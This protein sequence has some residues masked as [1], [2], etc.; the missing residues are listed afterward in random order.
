M[1]QHIV[2]A[3]SRTYR[4]HCPGQPSLGHVL[5]TNNA[6]P[7]P[8]RPLLPPPLLDR[9]EEALDTLSSFQRTYRDPLID[10]ASAT[11]LAFARTHLL[12]LLPASIRS[13]ERAN[14]PLFGD[15]RKQYMQLLFQTDVDDEPTDEEQALRRQLAV[16]L[17]TFGWTSIAAVVA[18]PLMLLSLP[19]LLYI[20]G[21]FFHESYRQ[22]VYERRFGVMSLASISIIGILQLGKLWA[23][24]FWSILF[25]PGN[26]LIARTRRTAKQQLVTLLGETPRFV[27][28]QHNDVDVRIPF[29]LLQVNDIIIVGAGETIPID[30]T[31]VSGTASI[32][33]HMLTGEAQ[34]AEKTKDERVYAATV[35][36]TGR[37]HILVEQ[38]G[39]A[40]VVAQIGHVL[41]RT[42]NY[43]PSIELR[44]LQIAESLVVPM[45][46]LSLATLPVFGIRQCSCCHIM[47]Y[48][49][50]NAYE[51][52]YQS[53]K[54]SAYSNR[55][56]YSGQRRTSV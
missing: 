10:Q 28:V 18:P 21:W 22:L 48:W 11:S 33:Q 38:T 30:G 31:I 2:K 40:T 49:V 13:I 32:D 41:E 24:S 25:V 3:A 45:V 53:A 17:A 36:L 12:P 51:C 50:S 9:T 56:W 6:T 27:W 37:L 44:G 29:D 46:V 54:L 42:I 4:R 35:V 55:L 52:A 20:V 39:V 34:P 7:H 8:P 47:P 19:G 23:L 1:L 15:A 43:H 5:A 26:I 16:C 14:I